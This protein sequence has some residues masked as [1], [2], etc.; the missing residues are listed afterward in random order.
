MST[1]VRHGYKLTEVGV[2]PE[3]WLVSS[4]GEEASVLTGYPFPSSGFT[5]AGIRLLRGSNVKR[6]TLDWAPQLTRYWPTNATTLRAF[7]LRSD[8]IVV[9]MDGALVGRSFSVISARDLPALLVQR[10]ARL[11]SLHADPGLL[12]TW[13]ASDRFVRHVDFVKTHTAIPHISPKD[14]LG[15]RLAL[16]SSREEQQNIASATSDVD[17]LLGSMDRLLAKKRDLKQ[18][19]MQELL[20]GRTRLP[21]FHGEWE[22]RRLSDHLTILRNGT[23]S[24]ADLASQGRVHYLH[25]GDIHGCREVSISPE[26]LPFLPAAKASSLDRLQDG[27]LIFADA[28]EDIVGVSKSVE[29]CGSKGA[30][31]VA[32]LH[33]IAVRFDKQILANGFKGYLQHCGPFSEHLRR[34]AAGTKVLATNRAHIA[35]AELPLPPLAEQTAIASVLSDMDAEIAALERRR[36]KTKLLKQ[37]MMQELLTGRTR[38]I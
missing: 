32:G 5:D 2:I 27:D 17:S 1:A 6:G 34:L 9:A 14:I 31:I 13:I 30:E 18:A 29:I 24:R 37:A 26:S 20:I 10:V 22:K 4:I 33:T 12:S 21:G 3:D 38:L 36:D 35:S 28:S 25:Y 19:T 7:A 11:R 15:F 16:P 23:N 8:D